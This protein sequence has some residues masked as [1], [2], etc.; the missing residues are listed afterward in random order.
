MSNST[1]GAPPAE[2]TSLSVNVVVALAFGHAAF[3]VKTSAS[4]SVVIADAVPD[5][6][7]TPLPSLVRPLKPEPS[8]SAPPAPPTVIVSVSVAAATRSPIVTLLK[9]VTDAST[10]VDWPPIVPVIV[11]AATTKPL[12]VIS[13]TAPSP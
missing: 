11:G 3:G 6:E 1:A 4:S 9:G 5:N 12:S 7:Y 2:L 10:V 13:N 8:M